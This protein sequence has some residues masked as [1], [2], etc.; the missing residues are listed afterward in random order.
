M[1]EAGA[2]SRSRNSA[3]AVAPRAAGGAD[4]AQ[5]GE[6]GVYSPYNNPGAAQF[7]SERA[8]IR[9]CRCVHRRRHRSGE[10]LFGLFDDTIERL[11]KIVNEPE[12]RGTRHP[13]PAF[14]AGLL[15]TATHVP[16]GM[17]VLDAASC[18]SI[19]RSRRSPRSA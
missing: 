2:S 14:I 17:Q 12:Q 10:D 8:N 11:L 5:P 15:V 19:S 1:R 13:V 18:S 6:S 9:S 7:L 3:D 4:E 16:L